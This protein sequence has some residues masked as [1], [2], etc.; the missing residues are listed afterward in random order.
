M[1]SF[2]SEIKKCPAFVEAIEFIFETKIDDVKVTS[3]SFKLESFPVDRELGTTVVTNI[4]LE[5][6]GYYDWRLILE[7]SFHRRVYISIWSDKPG[8]EIS[9]P[10][11]AYMLVHGLY[12]PPYIYLEGLDTNKMPYMLY[13]A[14]RYILSN[15]EPWMI[16]HLFD[17][18]EVPLQEWFNICDG[19]GLIESK[20]IL[21][22]L[23]H[24]RNKP[25][26]ECFRL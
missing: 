4:D 9:A 16:E 8:V 17:I 14:A 21:L 19:D 20:M 15:G 26:T 12:K 5:K 2:H 25:E 22:R 11:C 23:N 13:V 3:Y 1:S 10:Y 18:T 7:D 24:E 6:Q